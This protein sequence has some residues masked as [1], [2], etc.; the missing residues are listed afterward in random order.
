MTQYILRRLALAIPV[1]LGVTFITFSMLLLTGDPTGALAGEHATPEM[2]AL[3][4]EKL[5]LDDPFFVQYGRY[6]S[7]LMKGDFGTS[8]MTKSPVINEL[9][10]YLPATIELAMAAMFI[11]IIF[12]IPL[13]AI[14]G[15]KHNTF[16]DLGTTVGALI[17]VSMPIF[18]LG[19]MLLWFFG[20]KLG[21]FPTSGRIDPSVNLE[22]KTNFYILDSILTGNMP[23]LKSALHHLAL[24]AIALAT[25]PTAFIARITRSAMLD[26]LNEEYIRTARAKG[27]NEF[28]VV[29]K[30]AIKN[31]MLPVITVIGLQTGYLLGGAILTETI[32]SWPGMGRWIVNGIVSRNFPVVQTG[33]LVFALTFVFV[34]LIVDVSYA[35]F[36]PRIRYQ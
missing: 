2:R 35:L 23:A 25:I 10:K 15:Y 5:G 13:G 14:A 18:W 16:I 30:H 27:L 29:G 3:V 4:R 28:L 22:I 31:A 32:F 12:G 6:L 36:D 7:N 33:V 1:I 8:V 26:V 24:P 17:G 21:L 9:K 34:N 19:L 11:A 20:L